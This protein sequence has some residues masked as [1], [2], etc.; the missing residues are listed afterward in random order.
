MPKDFTTVHWVIGNPFSNDDWAVDTADRVEQVVGTVRDR[1]TNNI[2]KL[3]RGI[4]FGLIGFII[5]VA[6]IAIVLIM[7]TRGLQSLISLATGNTGIDHSRS[8]YVSYL[9]SGLLMLTL[10]GLVMRRRRSPD[11]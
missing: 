9:I 8:V 10:G 2:V 5:G 11:T 3:V 4:V 6:L 7:F 1:V